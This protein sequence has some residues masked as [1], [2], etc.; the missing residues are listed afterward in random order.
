MRQQDPALLGCPREHRRIRLPRKPDVLHAHDVHRRSAATKC[1][2]DVV[3]EV[4]VR[5]EANH[6]GIGM[7]A[8]LRRRAGRAAARQQPLAESSRI[9]PCL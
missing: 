1:P 3:V 4:L 7:A 8:A 6:T 2:Q 9:E 5:Q